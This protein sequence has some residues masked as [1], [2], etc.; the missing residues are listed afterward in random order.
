MS[1]ATHKR[2][3]SIGR[4]LSVNKEGLVTISGVSLPKNTTLMCANESAVVIKVPAHSYF[5]GQGI[6]G[7]APTEV[8]VFQVIEEM[9]C[10]ELEAGRWIVEP[11][12]A[13]EAKSIK[14]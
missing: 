10:S 9:E 5:V 13:W 6:R 8:K 3:T 14:K 11:M 4:F 1:I 12:I 7:N 2:T